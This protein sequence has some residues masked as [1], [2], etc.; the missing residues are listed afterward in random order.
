[1]LIGLMMDQNK[2]VA[3]GIRDP[4]TSNGLVDYAFVKSH[5]ILEPE[6]LKKNFIVEANVSFLNCL[7]DS[8]SSYVA[9][10]YLTKEGKTGPQ[11]K[12]QFLREIKLLQMCKNCLEKVPTKDHVLSI[13]L[14]DAE[15]LCNRFCEPCW[16]EKQ[17]C[18]ECSGNYERFH[19]CVR[20]CESC[21]RDGIQCLK[22]VVLVLTSIAKKAT[23]K[24]WNA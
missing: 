22:I 23:K 5:L 20:P 18:A 12:E 17:V 4:S 21:I 16:N 24:L 9:Y 6:F 13:S 19:P 11:I 2:K 14:K 1:M 8:C 10:N 7:D 15:A 3:I